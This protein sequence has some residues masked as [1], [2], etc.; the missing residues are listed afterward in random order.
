MHD[1]LYPSLATLAWIATGYRQLVSMRRGS[2]TPARHAV[3][4]AIGL[5]AVTFTVSTPAVWTFLDRVTGVNN[6]AALI[7]HLCVVGFSTTVQVLLLWWANPAETARRKARR[8]Y[9]F[10][11]AVAVCLL[12]LFVLAGP[13]ESRSSDFVATYAGR[14]HFAVYLVAY[15]AA[16]ATGLVDI[17]RIC[18]PYARL[19]GRG[20]LRVGLRTTAAGA[21]VGLV[22]CAARAMDVIGHAAGWNVLRWEF[23]IPLSSSLGALLVIVGLTMPAWVPRV[24]ALAGTGRRLRQLRQLRPLWSELTDA[25]PAVRLSA[26]ARSRGPWRPGQRLHRRVIEIYDARH[27]LRPYLDD[28]VADDARQHGEAEGLRGDDLAAAVEAA[29]LRAGLA[30]ARTDA[31]PRRPE[32]PVGPTADIDEAR[33]VEQLTRVARAFARSPR[34]S[35]LVQVDP[36]PT[37]SSA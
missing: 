34:A 26:D 31:R 35:T 8:R 1:L 7:A 17:I 12:V 30:A 20:S 22:Y 16:F 2:G 23:I 10:L 28:A 25:V 18:W 14:P 4:V 24:S 33:E 15:L 32:Q 11:V 21:V 3:T 37:G 27:A 9:L 13:T 6:I 29:K 5:L 19:V 36:A